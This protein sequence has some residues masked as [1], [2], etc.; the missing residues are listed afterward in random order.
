MDNESHKA[1][2]PTGTRKAESS[3]ENE[4]K[5]TKAPHES[6][7]N[8]NA[9][10]A[11]HQETQIFITPEEGWR[12]WIVKLSKILGSTCLIRNC[13]TLL[14]CC[15]ILIV[16]L[17]VSTLLGGTSQF[18][19]FQDSL[20]EAYATF[21][22]YIFE[23]IPSALS[24]KLSELQNPN[25]SFILR[26]MDTFAFYLDSLELVFALIVIGGIVGHNYSLSCEMRH[27]S[28]MGLRQF[29]H[30]LGWIW[31]TIWLVTLI[32]LLCGFVFSVEIAQMVLALAC[33]SLG[34]Y[35]VCF[36]SQRTR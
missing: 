23:V 11:S 27:S 5:A 19:K 4:I 15:A 17:L 18:E 2:T 36:Y 13:K 22:F 26:V 31:L 8:K 3:H 24:T 28:I 34:F 35:L 6:M 7:E 25:H 14:R 21:A 12:K 10:R 20:T 33:F 29:T 9:Q 32:L 30:P 1:T 16:L